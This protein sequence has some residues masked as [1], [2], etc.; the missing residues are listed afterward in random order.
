MNYDNADLVVVGAGFFGL[1]LAECAARV[2]GLRVLVLERRDHVGGNA[3]SRIDPE[4]GDE[5]HVYGSHIF[6]TNSEEVWH[7][8]HRFTGFTAY[9]HHVFTRHAGRVFPMP[10]T[11]GTICQFFGRAFTPD[12][13]CVMLATQTLEAASSKPVNLAEKAISLIGRPLYEAFIRGYTAKQW[14]TD[15][16]DLPVDII[17]RLPV[18]FTYDA[19]YFDDRFEGLPSE[20]YAAIFKRMTD[21]PNIR[22]WLKTDF[23]DV[24][25]QLPAN[26]PIIYTGPI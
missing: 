12:E 26:V 22:V 20:G 23:F 3:H 18:R 21:H 7:Y 8:L 17:T 24:R 11:L 14:Q 5:V 4:S 10:I 25:S 15:P 13:A 16:R 6:H 1:T 19:R 2:L 9:R